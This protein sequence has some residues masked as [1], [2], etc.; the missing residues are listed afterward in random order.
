MATYPTVSV[1]F[2]TFTLPR[3]ST[4]NATWQLAAWQ[5][6]GLIKAYTAEV[7]RYSMAYNFAKPW[8]TVVDA[9]GPVVV[10]TAMN[11]AVAVVAMPTAKKQK[12]QMC[13]NNAL[14]RG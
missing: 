5:D 7:L 6:T 4:K 11:S 3:R 12:K 10:W 9:V 1:C 2:Y 14:T 8:A 13:V